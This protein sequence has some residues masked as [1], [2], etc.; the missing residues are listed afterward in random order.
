MM[1]L[2]ILA[3]YHQA[4]MIYRLLSWTINGVSPSK[5]PIVVKPGE[6]LAIRAEAQSW[7]PFDALELLWNGEA[8]A[9]TKPTTASPSFAELDWQGSPD[10]HG[11]L[12]LRCRGSQPITDRPSNQAIFA[13]WSAVP[14]KLADRP[15]KPIDA[16]SRDRLLRE[17]DATLAWSREQANCTTPHDRERMVH[18]F[19]AARAKWLERCGS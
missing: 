2:F 5:Q 17:L 14:V 13:Q 4:N 6:P 10:D 16:K 7:L 1:M 3:S 11:W 15:A 8:I 9:A 19:E 18:V 12:A